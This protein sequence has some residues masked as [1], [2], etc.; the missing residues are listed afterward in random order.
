MIHA[1]SVLWQKNHSFTARP[2][3]LI[4]TYI[5]TQNFPVGQGMKGGN[6]AIRAVNH[7]PDSCLNGIDIVIPDMIPGI[8]R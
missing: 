5:S 4:D 1:D 2:R 8:A 7:P 6:K 3:D